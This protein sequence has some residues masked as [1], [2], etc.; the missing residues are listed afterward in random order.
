MHP[1]EWPVVLLFFANLFLLLTAYYILKVIRE[2]LILLGG[3]AVSRSYARGLQAGL[4]FLVIPI[5]GA[6]ANRTEPAKLVKWIFAFFVASLG[7]F[8][9][10]GRLNLSI[11]FPFFVWLGIFSTLSI[12]QFWSLANDILTESEGKRLFPIIAAGGTLGGILGAQIAA[13]AAKF[14][15][16]Y[17]LMLGAATLLA[18][19]MWLT[20]RSHHAGLGHRERVPDGP[21]QERDERGGFGLLIGDRYLLLIALSVLVLNFVNTTGDF[22]LAQMVNADAHALPAADRK[23]FIAAFYGDFQTW[24]STLTAVVQIVVVGRVFKKVGIGRALLFL[25]LLAV[26]GYGAAVFLP[27]LAVI[28][29]VKVVENS[30]DYSLQNTIQQALFLPTSRD[31]KYKAKSAID[32]LSVRLGDLASTG[33]VVVGTTL[34]L[35][36]KGFALVNVAAGLVWI[37]LAV[38]L[39]QRQ[40]ALV[41]AAAAREAREQAAATTAAL[42]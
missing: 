1:H 21:P 10:L 26:G 20:H 36:T 35:S 38:N 2:P 29:T 11:G 16:P 7:A 5:Y 17:H 12:A 14:L 37:W 3:G 15:H 6:L 25:P 34:H 8:F 40:Q 13:R 24:V 32:T 9:G 41:T 31:A 4:L 19:C 30:T 39:R 18:I 33:L 28:G 22:I 23:Q 42:A 27:L